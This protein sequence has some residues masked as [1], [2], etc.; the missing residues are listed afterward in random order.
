MSTP[1]HFDTLYNV[2][3][4][5]V[6]FTGALPEV[7]QATITALY[8]KAGF[9]PIS[10]DADVDMIFTTNVLGPDGMTYIKVPQ[11]KFFATVALLKAYIDGLG[12]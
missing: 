1:T 2:G 7:S 6:I 8:F 5:G 11:G 9:D 3:D 4:Q 10:F 12:L